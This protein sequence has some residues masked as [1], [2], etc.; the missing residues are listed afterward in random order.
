[1]RFAKNADDAEQSTDA[2]GAEVCRK[3][4]E[5][6]QSC[7]VV[8]HQTGT[9]QADEGDEQ[10]DAYGDAPLEA[11]GNGIEDGLPDVGQGQHNEDKA[12]HEDCQQSNLPGVAHVAADRKGHIGIEAHACGQGKGQVGHQRHAGG[13]DKGGQG[14][15]QQHGSGIH[16]GSRENAGVH[17]Q[18]VSHCHEGGKTGGDFCS[19]GGVVFF[20]LEKLF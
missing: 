4:S 1:M 16:A 9:L 11:Q 14:R 7:A 8:H 20:Q 17:S 5:A 18:N 3:I 2:L 19:D 12:F 6:H 13:A 15:C 10:A